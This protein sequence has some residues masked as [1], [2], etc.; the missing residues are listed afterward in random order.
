MKKIKKSQVVIWTFIQEIST[1]SHPP[2]K[3]HYVLIVYAKL[4]GWLAD[5][6]HMTGH[7]TTGKE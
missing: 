7:S 1:L 4:R 5:Q 2:A 3:L 6:S